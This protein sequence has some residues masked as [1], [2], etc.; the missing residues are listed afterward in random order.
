MLQNTRVTAFTVSELVKENQQG[1]VKLREVSSYKASAAS[2][3]KFLVT[4]VAGWRLF[5]VVGGSSI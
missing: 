4:M 1:G 5:G 3:M 2:V